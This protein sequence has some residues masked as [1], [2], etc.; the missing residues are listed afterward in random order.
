MAKTKA[1]ISCAVIA[2]LIC[3]FLFTYTKSQFSHN[4]AHIFLEILETALCNIFGNLNGVRETANKGCSNE[5]FGTHEKVSGCK[6][7]VAQ[8]SSQ[9]ISILCIAI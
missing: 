4:E 2:Q 7:H 8:I 1:L 5:H 3:V 9:R 6:V